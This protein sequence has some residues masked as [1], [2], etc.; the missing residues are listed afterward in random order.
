[1]PYMI[2]AHNTL[3]AY[4]PRKWWMRP[5]AFVYKCQSK[6]LDSLI[7]RG[8]TFF[9]I[10]IRYDKGFLRGCHGYADFDC[11]L[12]YAIY[13]IATS[14][15][16]P[17]IRLILEKGDDADKKRFI[18]GC[19][20]LEHFYPYVKFI[21]GNFKPTWERLYT[22]KNDDIHD[23]IV[24]YVGSMQTWWGKICPWLYAKIK[25]KKNLAEAKA[26]PDKYYLFDYL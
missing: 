14:V 11:N 20:C 2:G 5:F 21:G 10:R 8:V 24:Q 15:S 22:F 26:T 12:S 6:G 16:N 19:E 3:S 9:D 4:P 7:E 25:N 1:M 17:T 13:L 23:N 18:E